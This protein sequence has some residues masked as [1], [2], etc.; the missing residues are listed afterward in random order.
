MESS[1]AD[2]KFGLSSA[3]RSESSLRN[4]KHITNQGEPPMFKV[5]FK[6]TNLLPKRSLTGRSMSLMVVNTNM[7]PKFHKAVNFLSK[8]YSTGGEEGMMAKVD[9]N[10]Q[11]EAYGMSIGPSELN[12]LRDGC[13]GVKFPKVFKEYMHDYKPCM[14]L[15][16]PHVS[17]A[18]QVIAKLG[19]ASSFMVEAVEFSGEFG[20]FGMILSRLRLSRPT[21]NSF[22]FQL[23]GDFNAIL[24]GGDKAGGTQRDEAGGDKPSWRWEVTGTCS[25]RSAF[26]ELHKINCDVRSSM[27]NVA[28]EF[29]GTHHVSCFIWLAL[30]QRL[31][32]HSE[33]SRRGISSDNLCPVCGNLAHNSVLDRSELRWRH[34]FGIMIWRLWKQRNCFV[35]QG[36]V[37][38]TQEII[39]STLAWART[40][41]HQPQPT[42][43]SLDQNRIRKQWK[44]PNMEVLKVNTDG[45]VSPRASVAASGGV[46]RDSEGRWI[47]CFTRNIGR[48]SV[49]HAELW[50]IMDG[51]LTCIDPSIVRRIRDILKRPWKV[52]ISHVNGGSNEVADA[53]ARLGRSGS[54]GLCCFREVPVEIQHWLDKDKRGM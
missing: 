27:W 18:D 8:Q 44:P 21:L 46:I 42:Q 26:S 47:L 41:R 9:R 36:Q 22:M 7:D 34:C 16:E 19:F 23:R 48:C 52:V 17:K 37:W 5:V 32:T 49:L 39:R 28:W 14:A 45:V 13:G 50:A 6:E 30:R 10:I 4:G 29:D 12:A 15:L 25:V 43:R 31:M 35:F 3:A 51:L 33:R 1:N 20:F 40:I 54:P 2:T 38:S 53:L 11:E 24:S